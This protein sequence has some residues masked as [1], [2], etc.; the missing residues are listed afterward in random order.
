MSAF[1]I[2]AP[3][4]ISRRAAGCKADTRL[5]GEMMSES[6]KTGRLS[7]CGSTWA[8]AVCRS[9]PSQK[10]FCALEPE[11]LLALALPPGR[12]LAAAAA[13]ADELLLFAAA[14]EELEAC[15]LAERAPVREDEE[16]RCLFAPR[17]CSPSSEDSSRSTVFELWYASGR[18][19]FCRSSRSASSLARSAR[20]ALAGSVGAA[21]V[22]AA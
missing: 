20:N 8:L 19:R 4:L 7:F 22:G 5:T 13:A 6:R 17:V 2:R 1:C 14:V 11:P 12:A 10:T 15:V 3:E 21:G 18:W 9:S 16:M